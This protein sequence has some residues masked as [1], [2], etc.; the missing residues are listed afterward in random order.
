LTV[1]NSVVLS[2][3]V[4]VDL[5][6]ANATND[7]LVCN[8]TITYGGALNINYLSGPPASGASFK[9]FQAPS[10]SG[11]FTSINPATPGS[12]LTW[13]TSQLRTSGT[14]RV[15]AGTAGTSPRFGGITLSGTNLIVSGSNGVAAGNYYVLTSTNL[16]LPLTNWTRIATNAFDGTGSFKFTNNINPLAPSR[17]FLLRLP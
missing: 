12:G 4:N 17:F 14:I 3:S 15:V 2:G 11:S 16:G 10:Y 9:L 7:M 8:S 5:D 6:L 1:T 13:D